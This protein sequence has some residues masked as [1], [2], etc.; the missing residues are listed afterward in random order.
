[1]RSTRPRTDM[2]VLRASAPLASRKRMPELEQVLVDCLK[3]M[4]EV[5][6]SEGL[7]I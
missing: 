3:L 7:A 6:L 2:I 1:M 5:D 4:R